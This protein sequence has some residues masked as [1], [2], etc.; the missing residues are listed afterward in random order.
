MQEYFYDELK[1]KQNN[2]YRNK[3]LHLIF[4]KLNTMKPKFFLLIPTIFSCGSLFSQVNKI[5][6][7]P[8]QKTIV[9][10][11][12]IKKTSNS[13]PVK[14][15]NVPPPPT[16]LQSASISILTGDDGKDNDTY[17]FLD[18]LDNNK[19]VAATYNNIPNGKGFVGR[20][21]DE[22]YA[23]ASVS[24]PMI[25]ETS[26]PTGE[27]KLKGSLPLP[28][29]REANISD[30]S[31]GGEVRIKIQPNGHDTWKIQ[32]VS[33][34][35]SFNNDGNSPHKITWSNIVLSQNGVT[36]DLLFD[37]NFNPIQ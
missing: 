29:L 14:T 4:I 1:M 8:I 18:L 2:N 35:F 11:P 15:Q 23:G 36:R 31:S 26:V 24:L 22:Y 33:I 10:T 5:A 6:K 7:P 20:P 9:A 34:T 12:P 30:F 28:V 25:M 21:N 19:R 16:D 27:I 13:A 3:L 17:V 32:T 37:K